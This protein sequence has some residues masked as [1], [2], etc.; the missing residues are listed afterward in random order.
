MACP[1]TDPNGNGNGNGNGNQPPTLA[2][3]NFLVEDTISNT[4]T[5]GTLRGSDADGDTL[6]YEITAN[7]N[8]LFEV[9]LSNG[10][11]SLAAG[12]TLNFSNATSHT[13]TAQVSDGTDTDTARV[14]INVTNMPPPQYVVTNL[15]IV[16]TRFVNSTN[17]YFSNIVTVHNNISIDVVRAESTTNAG[18]FT[19][20]YVAG[21]N[22]TESYTS[23]IAD[24]SYSN[25]TEGVTFTVVTNFD[26]QTNDSPQDPTTTYQSNQGGSGAF[27]TNV[28]LA[29]TNAEVQTNFSTNFTTD[30]SGVDLSGGN[31]SYL[32]FV[33]FNFREA[34]LSNANLQAANLMN[35][36][37]F[38]TD[39]MQANCSSADL[40]GANLRG[41]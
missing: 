35:A 39:L 23:V 12:R 24:N 41:C 33:G 17:L 15:T 28:N 38:N 7:D 11:L 27:I 4:H 22:E 19:N 34:N 16:T 30:L 31:L 1:P 6:T 9:G 40:Q 5:I 29:H 25:S 21:T 37:L 8:G 2:D 20:L 26:V 3:T 18:S 32:N 13:I 14:T 36:N 10:Q